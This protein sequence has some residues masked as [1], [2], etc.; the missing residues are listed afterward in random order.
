LRVEREIAF[1]N[2]SER[3]FSKYFRRLSSFFQRG[4]ER[5][6]DKKPQR[7]GDA[8]K[9]NHGWTQMYADKELGICIHA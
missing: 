7:R 3:I 6:A 9:T 5:S 2:R 4:E 8:E 1:G